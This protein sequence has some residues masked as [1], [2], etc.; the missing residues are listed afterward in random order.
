VVARD[1][2]KILAINWDGIDH[3]AKIF[4]RISTK[5]FRNLSAII[6]KKLAGTQAKNILDGDGL[7]G[8]NSQN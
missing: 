8:A 5:L 4:P 7:T 1:D 6:S 3:I 2:S